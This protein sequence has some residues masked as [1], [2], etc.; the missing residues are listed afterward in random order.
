[1]SVRIIITAGESGRTLG[2]VLSGR[3]VSRRLITTLKRIDGGITRSERTV[4]TV[5]RVSAGDEILLKERDLKTLEPN[6][7]LSVPALYEDECLIVFDKPPFMPVHPSV[8]HQ[9]DTLGN[10]FAARFPEV[11]FRPV[12]R[13]DRDTSGCVICAKSRYSAAK[14]QKSFEKTYYAVC[15]GHPPTE[16][17]IDA[18]IARERASIIK[19]IVS[20]DGQPAVTNYRIAARN[21][22]YSLAEIHLETG[23]THQIRVHFS[24]IGFP[25][26]GDDL[27]GGSREDYSRQALH[28]SSVSFIHPETGLRVSVS[29]PLPENFH[30]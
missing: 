12:N 29:S 21:E 20:P 1:M 13:L 30:I 6:F 4:R 25:L 15:C 23:R 17:R 22:K 8:K 3:G 11:S 5:D 14:L 9:G 2:E 16:G 7:S 24:H 18:P 26:A 19:R 27:Y 28:C 10:F